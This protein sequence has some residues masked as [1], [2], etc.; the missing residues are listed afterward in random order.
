[1]KDSVSF[2]EPLNLSTVN[3]IQDDITPFYDNKTN[4]LYFSSDGYQ[5]LGGYD[6][7]S[8]DHEQG[9]GKV[10]HLGPEIN[11]RQHDI[12]YSVS[13]DPR[14]SYFSSDR[15]GSQYI[16]SKTKGCCFDIYKATENKL[17]LK[18]DL[19]T[20]NKQTL[21]ALN[22]VNV[23]LINEETGEVIYTDMHAEDNQYVVELDRD[24]KYLI[25]ADKPG[26]TSDTIPFNT[27]G[28]K[29]SETIVKKAYLA[30]DYIDLE[31][32][33]YDALTREDL[34]GATLVLRD[35]TDPTVEPITIKKLDSN[36]FNFPVKCGHTYQVTATRQGYTKELLTW[37]IDDCDS[38]KIISPMKRLM[39]DIM[40]KK[41]DLSRFIVVD[42]LDRIK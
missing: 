3:T 27:I 15:D 17:D 7:Y 39:I 14:V 31:V 12:Y 11:S 36:V 10:E 37:T 13:D 40:L 25:I 16:D 6:I 35:L 33:V 32:N 24:V 28:L 38:G 30:P 8:I 9:W 2:G 26:F 20:F 23:R 29:K 42:Y 5:G 34:D 4:I 21:E 18:L 41:S 19:T 22:G 1:M